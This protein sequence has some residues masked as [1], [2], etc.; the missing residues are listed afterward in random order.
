[1]CPTRFLCSLALGLALGGGSLA[2][3]L[4]AEAPEL[5]LQSPPAASVISVAVSPDGSLLASSSFEGGVRIYDARNGDLLRA[6]GGDGGRQVAFAP[7]GRSL[8]C[9]GY[10]MDR[11]LQLWDP[12]TGALL[13]TLEGHTEIETYAVAY[14]PNGRLLASA[15]TDKQIL[16]WELATGRLRHRITCQEFPAIALAFSPD[17]ATLA[18]GGGDRS[19]R[20]WDV[21]SG[22]L[23]QKLE[24]HRDWVVSL[25]FTPN[26]KSLASGSCDWAFHRARDT[27]Y[28]GMPDPGC[29]SEWKLWD[30]ATGALR[31]TVIVPGRLLSLAFA[32]D[33]GSLACAVGTEARVYDLARESRGGGGRIAARHD[34]GVTCVAFAPDGRAL[35]SGSHDLTVRRT[36]LADGRA[37]WRLPG[38]WEQ[39]NAAALSPDASLLA[40]AGSDQRYAARVRPEGTR[41]GAAA[42]GPGAV[43]LWDARTGRLL[44][45]LG[46][47]PEQGMAVAISP[48]GRRVAAGGAG[49]DGAGVVRVWEAAAGAPVWSARER[50]AEV[51]AVA[52]A[53]DGSLLATAG[54]D[55]VV[56]LRSPDTGTVV[57]SLPGH[58]GGA[59]SLV[60]SADGSFLV[61]GAADGASH[62]WDPR[63]GER[64]RSFRPEGSKAAA[65]RYDRLI[66][67]TS[68]S[69]DGR[70]LAACTAS[71]GNTFGEP[72]QF[73][74][75]R[76][77]ERQGQVPAAPIGGRPIALSP[78]GAILA[79][80]GKSVRLWD[81]RT[82]R[83]LREL[84]GYFK[85]TQSLVFSAD[86]R[87]L[88]AGGSYGTTNV[89]EV[90]SGRHLVTLFAF[91]HDRK[92]RP[93][94]DWLSWTP[95]GYYDG[96]RGAERCLAWRVGG[97]L[98]APGSPG[99]ERR[100]PDRVRAALSPAATSS[101]A[102]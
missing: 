57:R 28:F 16:V 92:G 34:G 83:R 13:R 46:G 89:W 67:A 53:P 8:V 81:V 51:L 18:S 63:T 31:R 20:L 90:A 74:D 100:R 10:H 5:V 24:G 29:E 58:G 35:F 71:V 86:G 17:G 9:A 19:V 12:H 55:G 61:C 40:T 70:T 1:M 68:L 56:R 62:L 48:D 37:E 2:G 42:L 22:R 91:S 23:R 93:S 54:T 49:A 73:W 45:R 99:L 41:A 94:E 80:G 95:E 79:T 21:S 76:T 11:R 65:V 98:R 36:R 69:P 60:F 38:A 4:P 66:T 77:G 101:A 59:T 82:G 26:G 25:A 43:R 88:V 44:R 64:L 3:A 15:G 75:T 102:R 14:S 72:V 6:L 96:S 52:F 85:K 30:A 47:G 7:D 78:D 50:A 27:L 39:V 33:G 87:I 84:G 32:P 97:E